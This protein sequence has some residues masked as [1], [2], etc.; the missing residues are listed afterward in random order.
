MD[1]APQIFQDTIS[2]EESSED[3]K[4][5]PDF[6][7]EASNFIRL[8]TS[9]N[10]TT[11]NPPRCPSSCPITSPV[12]LIISA[13]TFQTTQETST[14][15]QQIGGGEKIRQMT[16]LFYSKFFQDPHLDLFI[17]NRND[18]HA[19]RLASWI[20]E[21]MGGEGNVWTQ[22]RVLR[23]MNPVPLVLAGG[24]EHV[25]H[26]RTSAHS[27]A[28]FCPKRAQEHVGRR[29]KLHDSR[30]WMR[31]MFWSAREVGL[32]DSPTGAQ[33]EAQRFFSFLL[34]FSFFFFYRL[35]PKISFF[36][37]SFLFFLF[38]LFI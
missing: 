25:V 14:L 26:D 19:E 35:L 34:P 23:S 11:T 27:A 36:F 31:L 38:F 24:R 4:N 7:A 9:I 21:K 16:N 3:S 15:L 10:N 2:Y 22:E 5:D 29:F 1:P 30:I 37:F 33:S 8:Q 18:P 17:N 12:P 6:Q 13:N 28:W 20:I 32:F